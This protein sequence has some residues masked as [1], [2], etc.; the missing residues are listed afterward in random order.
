MNSPART[1]E[2]NSGPEHAMPCKLLFHL[3]YKQQLQAV[4]INKQ[5]KN[6]KNNVWKT[7][8]EEK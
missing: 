4:L 3:S 1:V 8:T 5:T 6:T 7:S 2:K